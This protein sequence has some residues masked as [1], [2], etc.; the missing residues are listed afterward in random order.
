MANLIVGIF[1]HCE[2]Q[3]LESALSAQ[4][5]IDVSRLKVVTKDARSDAHGNSVLDF[6]FVDEEL[7]IGAPSQGQT[8]GTGMLSDSGGTS[9]PGLSASGPALAG[10][11]SPST[12]SANYL[13]NFAIPSDE[14]GNF[15]DAVEAGR[16]VVVYQLAP[17]ENAESLQAAFKSTGL[18]NVRTY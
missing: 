16:C 10:F 8:H 15:N 2:P 3:T 17:T 13:G 9:V 14:I 12:P 18:R 7:A 11:G 5:S 6:V 1:E 4:A